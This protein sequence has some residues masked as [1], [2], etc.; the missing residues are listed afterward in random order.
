MSDGAEDRPADEAVIPGEAEGGEEECGGGADDCGE[1]ESAEEAF[2]GFSGGE[3]GDEFV[4]AD[5]VAGGVG[6]DVGGFDDGD[7][8]QDHPGG[9]GHA[10]GQEKAGK[11]AE[12]DDGQEGGAGI[13]HGAFDAVVAGVHD[14]GGDERE[15]EDGGDEVVGFDGAEGAAEGV[16]GG[17]FEDGE[18]SCA[19][20]AGGVAHGGGHGGGGVGGLEGGG[21]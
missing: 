13:G 6:A 9:V 12:I 7:D 19:F 3:P 21:L 16:P 15:G 10:D 4:A 20:L 8:G 1:E 17:G 2:D 11:D 18:L 14:D 5:G